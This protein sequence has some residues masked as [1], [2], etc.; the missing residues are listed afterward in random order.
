MYNSPILCLPSVTNTLPSVFWSLAAVSSSEVVTSA[1]VDTILQDLITA[2]REPG[3]R[4]T[5]K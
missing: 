5:N 3:D 2:D 1:A 4:D